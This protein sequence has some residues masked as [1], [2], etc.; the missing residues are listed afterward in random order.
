MEISGLDELE[1]PVALVIDNEILAESIGAK[2]SEI[3]SAEALLLVWL[4]P[5]NPPGAAMAMV[6]IKAIAKVEPPIMARYFWAKVCLVLNFSLAD[7]LAVLA[8]LASSALLALRLFILLNS[9]VFATPPLFSSFMVIIGY[10]YDN[11]TE[12]KRMQILT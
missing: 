6:E 4:E 10:V 5:N 12:H 2:V 3:V 7:S 8:V 9:L 1:L 11:N